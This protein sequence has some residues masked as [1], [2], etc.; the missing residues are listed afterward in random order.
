MD[1]MHLLTH[2]IKNTWRRGKVVSVLFL[3]I[4]GAFPN[5]NIDRLLHNM[6]LHRIP[7]PYVLFVDRMICGCRTSLKFD[8]YISDTFDI[9]TG[10][11]QGDPLSM[12]LYLFYNADLLDIPAS[13]NEAALGYVDDT[14]LYAEGDNLQDTN[15]T[16]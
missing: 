3:D 13:R 1:S 15:D 12:L 9:P 8:D 14:M 7:E 2:K 16:L 11:G 6:H 5:T 10:I 4:E